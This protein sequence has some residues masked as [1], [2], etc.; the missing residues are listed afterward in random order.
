[1]R[2]EPKRDRRQERHE[3]T[4]DEIVATAWEMV[5]AEGLA[6]LSL[7]ALARSVGLEAQSLYNYFPS[8]HAIYDV[9]F[10]RANAELLARLE[11]DPEP[12]DPAEG[13][14]QRARL[15]VEVCIEDA[16]RYELLFQRHIPGFEPTEGSYALARQSLDGT[17]R[18]LARAGLSDE[19][20]LEVW[21]SLTGGLVAQQMANDPGGRR[22][23]RHLDEVVDMFLT[24][25]K[26]SRRA[27]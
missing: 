17:R 19:A 13:L 12:E 9:M 8:K 4:R 25:T 27:I 3:A 16:A 14:H 26:P 21:T 11:R 23:V 6:A 20:H 15:F 10:G 22:Y 1:M 2:S 5:R 18:C 24:H 7:R